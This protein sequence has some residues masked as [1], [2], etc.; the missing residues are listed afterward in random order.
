MKLSDSFWQAAVDEIKQGYRFE[1]NRN[2]FN[3]LFCS[4]RTEQGIIYKEAPEIYCDAEKAIQN[5]IRQAHIS[6]LQELLKLDKRWTGL[7]ELQSRLVAQ[8]STGASDQE[9]M[10]AI[11]AA[12]ISTIR[13]HRFLLREKTKQAKLCLAIGE[14]MELPVERKPQVILTEEQKILTSYFPH[15]VA[16]PLSSF[17]TREK[18][19]LI[20]LNQIA[21]RFSP[22]QTYSEKEVNAILSA[23]YSDHVLLRRLL[24]DYGFLT[25]KADGSEYRRSITIPPTTGKDEPDMDRKK[26]LI[27]QYK[28]TPLPMGVFQIKNNVNGKLLII[29]AQDIPGIINRHRLELDRGIH[30]NPELQADWV[31]FGADAFSFDIL[32][33]LK[34]E[35]S[36]PEDRPKAL[37][38]LLDHWLEELQPFEPAGYHK[39]K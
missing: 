39:K 22:D 24:I 17:P 8:F 18:R 28:D 7:T 4:F 5:H 36:L 33:A 1:K 12:S 16:G 26:E 9:I 23:V 31:H 19:R 6:P 34:P 14:L 37:S 25:R 20:L 11:G 35:E 32:A 27:R 30:R 15:G 2:S 13:N 21:T 29:K 3:C 38:V 10:S